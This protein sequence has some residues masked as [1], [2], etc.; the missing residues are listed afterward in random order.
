LDLDWL[1]QALL[2]MGL[3]AL[4]ALMGALILW[5]LYAL[6]KISRWIIEQGSGRIKAWMAAVIKDPEGEEAQQIG[7]ITGVA[8]SYA[9]QGLEE[10]ASTKEGRERLAPLMEMV[11]AHI[12]QSIFATW[13]HI[14]NKLKETGEGV[15]GMDAFSIPPEILGMGEKMLPKGLKDAGIGVSQLVKLAGFLSRYG[16]NGSSAS[17]SSGAGSDI[18]R[19][20]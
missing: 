3:G 13:G 7:R 1:V 19:I 17:P 8:F 11:Q 2:T 10:L 4:G 9:L 14:L 6:P 20:R 16:G 5:K 18:Y 15:P 12:Q